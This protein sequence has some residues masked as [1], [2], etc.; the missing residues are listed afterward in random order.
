MRCSRVLEDVLDLLLA[1]VLFHC[2]KQIRQPVDFVEPNRVPARASEPN[3]S[4]EAVVNS[5]HWPCQ[6]RAKRHEHGSTL[7]VV[8]LPGGVGVGVGVFFK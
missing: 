2:V 1:R 7:P 5:L 4:I 6:Q 3:C 8:R